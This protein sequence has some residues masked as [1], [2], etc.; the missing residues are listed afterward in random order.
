MSTVAE[1]RAS[2]AGVTW[3][4]SEL[5]SGTEDARI[6][7]DLEEALTRARAF[8]DTYRGK[9]T[10]RISAPELAK[11]M[12]DLEG[13]LD[14][15]YRPACYAQL[16]HAGD[17]ASPPAGA[18]LQSVQEKTTDI[19]NQLIFFDL[20]WVDL[21]DEA[22]ARLM[23]HPDLARYRHHLENVRKYKP[24][25]LAEGE[26]R[27]VA[28]LTNTGSAA[29]QRLFD[30]HL[31][32]MRFTVNLPSGMAEMSEEEVLALLHDSDRLKRKAGADALTAGLKTSKRLLSFVFNNLVQDH[33]VNDRM[34]KYADPMDARHLAN[35]IAP[36]TVEA[37]LSACDRNAPIVERYYRMKAKLLG[38]K[39][40]A[41]YDRYAP[42]SQDD[43]IV[44]FTEARDTVLSAYGAFSPEMAGIAK[45][46]FEK[47][48]ID[49]EVRDGKRGGAF[50]HG[51]VPSTHPFVFANYTGGRR[52]VMTLAH[53][54]GHGVHQWLARRQGLFQADTPLTM[55]ETA[56]V[57]G[58]M[59]VFQRL[60]RE[61]PD[62]DAK[63]DL[64]C[65]KLEDSFAT[66]FRQAAMTRFEQKLHAGRR[67]YGELTI[68]QI[69]AYWIEVNQN[70][71]R[72]SVELREDYAL[73]W[74]YIPH[75]IHT[76]FYCYA[77]AFG[78]LLVLALYRRYEE[79]GPSFAPK[80]L[81]LLAAGGSE[82][83]EK[84]LAKVGIDIN[85]SDF[86]DGG[87]A[88]LGRMVDEIEKLIG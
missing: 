42:I 65:G 75:F 63:L 3:D 4:L 15:A 50:S 53:E 20:A 83:P 29:F 51:M 58:E 82:S 49:A 78:E 74:M 25:K 38:L 67:T 87:L 12:A 31:G 44:P 27:I 26:E 11:A 28:E 39:D 64:L 40:F 61:A 46:F 18:L 73:W 10:P 43:A 2:A 66:V 70:M 77:Y 19:G 17:T 34:R 23:A 71:F 52:D 24:H 33:A 88:V 9:V 80:Y 72:G 56:S 59:L 60:L 36:A 79:E 57:F 41:D 8:A 7:E 76:P 54:L 45:Q 21:E 48:W 32:D 68:E 81:E 84:L 6:R 30:E 13:L 22:A 85:Q 55:A 37:L 1:R 69:N 5:Y 62:R 47:R 16:I 14:L 86:W 35:E